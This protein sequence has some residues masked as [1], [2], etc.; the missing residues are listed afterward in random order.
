MSSSVPLQS[1]VAPILQSMI[2]SATIITLLGFILYGITVA[3]AY[4]YA[5]NTEEDAK[6]I[7]VLVVLVMLSET[8][9]SA[10]VLDSL[11]ELTTI[12]LTDFLDVD[13][14]TWNISFALLPELVLVVMV[15]GF[16][17]HRLWHLSDN[18]VVVTAGVGLMVVIRAAFKFVTFS[19]EYRS[20]TWTAFSEDPVALWTAEAAHIISAV[21][22]TLIAI[23]LLYY[24]SRRKSGVAR[25]VFIQFVPIPIGT[26]YYNRTDNVVNWVMIYAVNTGTITMLLSISTAVTFIVL[27]NNMTFVGLAT[28]LCRSY[29]NSFL[30]TLNARRRLRSH[31]GETVELGRRSI[32]VTAEKDLSDR[33]EQ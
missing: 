6:W 27:K 7:K 5:V 21:T 31:L 10:F 15:Q 12:D 30:G 8:C 9:F 13:L 26:S 33:L 24:L 25:F 19:Y 2:G 11:Y 22:D 29:A 20:H 32:E 14:L 3:Q 4:S 18:S 17:T 1:I 28:I 23:T 16:Y